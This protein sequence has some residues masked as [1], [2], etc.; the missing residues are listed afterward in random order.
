MAIHI[1][2]LFGDRFIPNIHYIHS[3]HIKHRLSIE[4][5]QIEDYNDL[6]PVPHFISPA[7]RMTSVFI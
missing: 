7:A 3:M 4:Y 1:A 5:R 6:T 2:L